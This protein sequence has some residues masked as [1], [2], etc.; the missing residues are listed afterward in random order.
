[1]NIRLIHL[2]YLSAVIYSN[3]QAAD[4]HQPASAQVHQSYRRAL[5][6]LPLAY[7]PQAIES[8]KRDLVPVQVPIVGDNL[9]EQLG[10]AYFL[11]VNAW[12]S[13]F[14]KLE[15]ASINKPILSKVLGRSELS[16]IFTDYA[17]HIVSRHP[18]GNK[19]VNAWLSKATQVIGDFADAQ[20]MTYLRQEDKLNRATAVI[21]TLQQLADKLSDGERALLLTIFA[22][23]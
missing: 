12:F 13:G 11:V 14:F 4:N 21:E 5:K 9:E 10:L 15:E 2:F 23:Q 1:M 16:G 19:D 7:L 3:V 18:Q 8:L 17:Q 20:H 6:P 22:V